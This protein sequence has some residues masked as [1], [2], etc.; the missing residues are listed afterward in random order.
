MSDKEHKEPFLSSKNKDE[1]SLW[2]KEIADVKKLKKSNIYN[3]KKTKNNQK[4]TKPKEKEKYI[5]KQNDTVSADTSFSFHEKPP[6]IDKTLSEKLRRGK[7]KID[8]KIDLHGLTQSEAYET[9]VKTITA[10]GQ[11]NKKCLLVITGKG[12]KTCDGEPEGILRERVPK[13]LVTPPLA[14]LVLMFQEA[15]IKHGGSG[16][17]YVLLRRRKTKT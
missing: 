3:T 9:L 2:D 14:P 11:R 12:R 16:A 5:S 8:Q 10:A 4:L 15:S 1:Q 7:I 13:W 17:F 6:Q